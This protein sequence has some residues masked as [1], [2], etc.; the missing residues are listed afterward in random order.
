VQ[1]QQKAI[2]FR[3]HSSELRGRVHYFIS[4]GL[5]GLSLQVWSSYRRWWKIFFFLL[6]FISYTVDEC[7]RVEHLRKGEGTWV[8]LIPKLLSRGHMV[9]ENNGWVHSFW[10]L[11]QFYF[12]VFFNTLPTPTVPVCMFL[13]TKVSIHRLIT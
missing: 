6:F 10:V 4:T 13:I 8:C 9:S 12:K 7:T 3:K 11:F 5:Q 1:Q 2:F